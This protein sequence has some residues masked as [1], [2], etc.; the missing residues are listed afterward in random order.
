M[1]DIG[2]FGHLNADPSARWDAD[3]EGRGP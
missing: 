2:D 3:A 1:T